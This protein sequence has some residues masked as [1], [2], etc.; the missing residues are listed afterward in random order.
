MASDIRRLKAKLLV[1]MIREKIYKQLL[2][3]H[4]NIQQPIDD[5]IDESLVEELIEMNTDFEPKNKRKSPPTSPSGRKKVQN[6]EVPKQC[7]FE[8]V[9]YTELSDDVKNLE[10]QSEDEKY[11]VV[12]DDEDEDEK[13][14]QKQSTTI[15]AVKETISQFISSL[16]TSRNYNILLTNIREQHCLAQSFIVPE[17]YK[18]FIQNHLEKV[19]EVFT[20]RGWTL[21]KISMNVFSR[22]LSPL[23][24][25]ITMT[26]GFEKKVIEP[27][28]IHQF[29]LSLE[30]YCN[31]LKTFN[32][33]DPI[34]VY[35]FFVNFSVCL[36]PLE[37]LSEMVVKAIS[38][39]LTYF[40]DENE[41]DPYAF[42]YLTKVDSDTG[43]RFWSMDC[44]L[45]KFTLELGLCI[46]NQCVELFKKIYKECLHT[47]TFI[48]N[49]KG[50]YHVLEY[51]CEQLLQNLFL[52]M[53][54][55]RF[56]TLLRTLVQKHSQFSA[57]PTMDVL[58]FVLDDKEQKLTWKEHV[59]DPK[60]VL[61][62]VQYIFD[63]IGETNAKKLCLN[64]EK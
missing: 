60:D 38:E 49:Y 59:S 64:Y 23:D 9:Y 53:N 30:V 37:T 22:L 39:T 51:Q 25:L 7:P 34:P 14:K 5:S 57:S 63:G 19:K 10:V 26:E 32:T 55:H 20:E 29:Q 52:S 40:G 8:G 46:K 58:D 45:E 56:N 50:K 17:D 11:V 35:K 24:Y 54:F 47:N 33:F 43:K 16:K 36:F 42:Y 3:R 48:E 15:E 12:I 21:K 62:V 44:R 27:E 13:Q 1:S 4:L 28:D 2:I 31:Q 18:N 61:D 6:T 41:L